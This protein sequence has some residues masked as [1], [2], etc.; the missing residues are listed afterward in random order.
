M[1]V[2]KAQVQANR[3]H[4]VE[5]AAALFRERGY[6]G[7]S[8]ADL[9]NAAGFTHGGFYKHFTSK[10][11]LMTEAAACGIAQMEA[12]TSQAERSALVRQY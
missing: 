11:A 8:V 6:D 7:V 12:R 3:A 9:M 10:A 5:T 1:K 2:S 4:I